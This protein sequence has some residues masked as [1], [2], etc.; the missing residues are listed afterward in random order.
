MG[1]LAEEGS[2]VNCLIIV[3]IFM[4]LGGIYRLGGRG[5]DFSHYLG[6]KPQRVGTIF[7]W[8]S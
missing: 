8:G 3:V 2:F 6:R 1:G 5:G 4:G 7:Y